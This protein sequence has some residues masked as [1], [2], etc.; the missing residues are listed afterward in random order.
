MSK[1]LEPPRDVWQAL[2]SAWHTGIFSISLFDELGSQ[3]VNVSQYNRSINDVLGSYQT[4][5]E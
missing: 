1:T 4:V 3:I 5:F 2:A